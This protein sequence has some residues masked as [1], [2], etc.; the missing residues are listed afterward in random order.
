MTVQ[1]S[2][3]VASFNGDGANKVFPIGYK[4]NSAADLVV[5]L[6]DD[7][8]K[9]TQ[10]LTLNS[11]F[12]VTGAGDEEGGVVTLTVAPTAVQRLS[13]IRIVD[14]LQLT[15]LRNQGKFY[16]EIHEDALDRL[17]MIAQQHKSDIDLSL[18]VAETDPKPSRIPSAAQRAGKLL[19]FDADGNPTATLPSADSSTELR[20][21]L[22]SAGLGDGISKVAGAQRVVGSIAELRALPESL[23]KS[24]FVTAYREGGP[25]AGGGV[26]TLRAGD[27]TTAD[28]G[29]A[30]IRDNLGRLW[31]LEHEGSINVCQYGAYGDGVT[32]D[33]PYWQAASN[34]LQSRGGGTLRYSENHLIDT[35]LRIGIYVRV[36]G[37]LG[38]AGEL[39]SQ[40][41]DYDS[42]RG[43]LFVNPTITIQTS[44]GSSISNCL[45]IRKGLD[46]PFADEADATAGILA[47]SGTAFTVGGQDSEFHH[48]LILG[49]EWAIKSSNYERIR[50][51]FVQGDCTNGILI[52]IC[53]D[54]T[55]LHGCHFWPFT[56]VHQTWTTNALL[57]RHGTAFKF[58]NMGDWTKVYFCFCYG[59]YRG[60][61]LAG[62]NS[63]T[64][65]NCGADSPGGYSG[66]IAVQ[67]SGNATDN[68]IVNFQAA[69]QDVAFYIFANVGCHQYLQNCD[70]WACGTHAVLLEG[71]GDLSVIGGTIR[72][73]PNGLTYNDTTKQSVFR[74]SGVRFRNISGGCVNAETSTDVFHLRDEGG[75]DF[76][77]NAVVLVAGSLQPTWVASADPLPVPSSGSFFKVTGTTSFGT[78]SGGWPGR[79]IALLFEGAL[80]VF[81]GANVRL[82]ANFVSSPDDV[83]ELVSDGVTWYA[84]SP[85]SVN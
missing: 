74:F 48:M 3:N 2:T 60:Y 35:A 1:T 18:R 84:V 72:D 50:C 64:L 58:T 79:K 30:Y 85:S 21:D 46:L 23:T 24:V 52:D 51:E 34:Y 78:I 17:T 77:T 10:I 36:E 83:L 16:A 65:F 25:T 45:V 22:G 63:M 43:V 56:T 81:D 66:Q 67:I 33:A 14:I 27:T 39:I 80:T 8:A 9:T 37:P 82:P 42:R 12:T 11:D 20:Q 40:S 4:F 13:I 73:T 47:F 53:S 31:A 41:W 7:E 15:D 61:E 19:A 32:D 68:R 75:C 29:G 71:I 70:A 59:Y 54:I 6:I 26:Y 76:G 57:R 62:V 44:D 28:D 38:M 49:F 5:T 69:A 55:Y